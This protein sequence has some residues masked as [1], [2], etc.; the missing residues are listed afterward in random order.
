MTPL[1]TL[2]EPEIA[3]PESD[4]KPMA[5]NTRQ[6]RCISR[7]HAAARLAAGGRA[8]VFVACDLL[9]YPL[10]VEVLSH[11]NTRPEMDKK[12]LEYEDLGVEEYVEYDP[13]TNALSAYR[14]GPAGGALV[15]QAFRGV[16]E[17]KTLPMRFDARGTE[18]EMLRPDGT[19]ILLDLEAEQQRL[20]EARRADAAQERA[21]AAERDRDAYRQR[22]DRLAALAGKLLAG[23]ASPDEIDELRRLQAP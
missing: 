10:V 11:H 18:L 17:A 23:Q 21:D 5:D 16:Y 13:E 3:Y 14:R 22:A 7:I 19:R 8:D 9:W 1:L 4:G 2:P 6:H 20:A 12:R 15:R